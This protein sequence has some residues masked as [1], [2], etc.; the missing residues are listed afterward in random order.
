MEDDFYKASTERL[1]KQPKAQQEKNQQ[2]KNAYERERPLT[3]AVMERLKKEIAFREKIDSVE[4]T[5]DPEMV[6]REI[7]VN[8]QVCSILRRELSFLEGKARM[9]DSKKLR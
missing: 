4:K 2:L 9:F 8:K 3:T 7:A 6:M 5:E 1:I